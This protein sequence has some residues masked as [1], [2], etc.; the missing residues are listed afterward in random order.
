MI[1]TFVVHLAVQGNRRN[2]HDAV[3]K[4]IPV[5]QRIGQ[6]GIV[7]VC[8]SVFENVLFDIRIIVVNAE[9]GIDAES[10]KGRIKDRHFVVVVRKYRGHQFER[11]GLFFF[12]C[13]VCAF[14]DVFRRVF[15]AAEQSGRTQQGDVA[16]GNGVGII[17]ESR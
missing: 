12:E 5:A 9:I 11:F 13:A 7:I 3:G 17:G 1:S 8:K 15:I 4:E 2:T 10:R 6:S 16:V 14:V